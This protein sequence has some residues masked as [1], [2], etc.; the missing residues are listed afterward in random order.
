MIADKFEVFDIFDDVFTVFV[1]V[2]SL[3]EG[4]EAL[5]SHDSV[6]FSTLALPAV[7][8]NAS[9]FG[10]GNC[11]FRVIASDHSDSDF[12]ILALLDGMWDGL[13]DGIHDAYHTD[14]NEIFVELFVGRVGVLVG[15]FSVGEE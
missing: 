15:A 4:A 10:D 11:G 2:E 13:S 12:G 14:H 7:R 8:E 1:L 6:V 5:S 9:F 3:D